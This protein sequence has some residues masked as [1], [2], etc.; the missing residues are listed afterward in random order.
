MAKKVTTIPATLDKNTS[1][2]IGSATIRRVAGY[3]RV[4]TDNDD[5]INSYE[6]Q[7]DYYTEYIKNRADWIFVKVYTDDGISGTSTAKRTGFNTM[8]EDALKGKI[9]LIVTKSVSRFARNTVDSLSTIRELKDNGIEVYFEKEN[10][11]TFD[12]SGELLLTIMSSLSQE[13]SRSIS[14]NV[15]WGVRKGMQ[16]GKVHV[17][18]SSFLGYDKGSDG[19]LVINEA[20]ADVVRRIYAFYIQGMALSGIA[21]RLNELEI[22]TPMGGKEWST[23]S[24]ERILKNEKYKGDAL[25]QKTYTPNYLTKKKRINQGEV[26][27]YYVEGNHPAIINPLVFDWVQKETES[28]GSNYSGKHIFSSRFIC[29]KCGSIL[30]RK[31]WHSKESYKRYVWQCIGKYA[32][33]RK[34]LKK[35]R[36]EG[37][38][39]N[40][41]EM[42]LIPDFSDTSDTS[43]STDPA[44]PTSTEDTVVIEDGLSAI[45]AGEVEMV[46]QEMPEAPGAEQ[47][48][49]QEGQETAEA[50]EAAAEADAEPIM[51]KVSRSKKLIC[52]TTSIHE[53]DLEKAFLKAVN[54][55]LQGRE[56]AIAAFELAKATIFDTSALEIDL[57]SV[58]A[59]IRSTSQRMK[60]IGS[61]NTNPDGYGIHSTISTANFSNFGSSEDVEVGT[62]DAD[63]D[64][65]SGAGTGAD[66]TYMDVT[67]SAENEARTAIRMRLEEAK[68]RQLKIR[69]KIKDKRKRKVTVDEFLA[70][71]KENRGRVEEFSPELFCSLVD[72]ATYKSNRDNTKELTFTFLNGQEIKVTV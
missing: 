45:E 52:P 57:V 46:E 7:V 36:Y 61:E 38:I 24:I 56:A 5:Q 67:S 40:P 15:T 35:N 2:P 9:D 69:K 32:I 64:E 44:F 60:L 47:T 17:A 6:A 29:E 26:P 71:L 20:Q 70:K 43:D 66:V 12:S 41:I 21:K 13:E 3:A 1:K 39:A 16:D 65:N 19:N 27:Q 68:Q 30:G 54:R 48:E 51:R 55:L 31:V 10:I 14:L 37:C 58:N 22:P 63:D 18:F 50:V 23:S 4:S 62:D 8:V 11:W 49:A 28:R 59:E 53:E 34:R 33:D 25:L 72:F 42:H